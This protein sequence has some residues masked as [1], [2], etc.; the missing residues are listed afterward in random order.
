[1]LK[2]E[3]YGSIYIK[4]DGFQELENPDFRNS[5]ENFHICYC[6]GAVGRSFVTNKNRQ[7]N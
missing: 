3:L 6:W 4:V 2:L 5:P 7:I 1:M